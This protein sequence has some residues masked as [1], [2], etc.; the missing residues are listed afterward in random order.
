[1]TTFDDS[2]A[3]IDSWVEVRS[4][5]STNFKALFGDQWGADD[6]DSIVGKLVTIFADTTDTLNQKLQ[7][8]VSAFDTAG[9]TGIALKNL[10]KM[11]NIGRI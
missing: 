7:Y 1:M 9:A 10:V 8:A 3:S 4:F 5:I 11:K 6:E 2:G